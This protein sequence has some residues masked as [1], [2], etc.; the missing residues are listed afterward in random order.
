MS[1][2]N[3]FSLVCSIKLCFSY[4]CLSQDFR[5]NMLSK[6]KNGNSKFATSKNK[7]ILFLNIFG[8]V[9]S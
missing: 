1:M 8:L 4:F 7:P 6:L 2:R 3:F 5:K 9:I